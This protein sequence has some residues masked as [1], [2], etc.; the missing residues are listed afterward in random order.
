[1]ATIVAHEFDAFF[2]D[3]GSCE[4]GLIQDR[5]KFVRTIV[6]IG[7]GVM[8]YLVHLVRPVL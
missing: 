4:F 2:A 1:M 5:E 7:P 8:D 6:Q 3:S